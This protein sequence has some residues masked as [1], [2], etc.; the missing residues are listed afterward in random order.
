ML[1]NRTN[2]SPLE[3]GRQALQR[4][5]HCKLESETIRLLVQVRTW[6]HGSD[7]RGFCRMPS[8]CPSRPRSGTLRTRSAVPATSGPR[9]ATEPAV[10]PR[11]RSERRGIRA[12]IRSGSWAGCNRGG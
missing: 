3:A 10:C 2:S 12:T 1:R 5:G 7:W 4:E 9:I 6:K 8:R 11:H